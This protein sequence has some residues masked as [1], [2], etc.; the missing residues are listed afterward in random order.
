MSENY[1][2][3]N[4]NL[5]RLHTI[6]V[7]VQ[8]QP[9]VLSRIV[10]IFSRRG[11][12]IESLVVSA[13][14]DPRFSTMTITVEGEEKEIIQ[15]I[16]QLAKLVNVLSVKE[17]Q[18]S[19]QVIER[20]LALVKIKIEKSERSN[21]LQIVDHFK[22]HTIDLTGDSVIVQIT[23]T[24]EKVDACIS[25]LKSYEIIELIRSGKII[26]KRGKEKT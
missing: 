12:N 3:L 8:N 23:G 2:H 13:T 24:T 26:M 5:E 21:L 19:Y 11:F 9:S 17:Y 4:K 25:L 20:E 1:T 16:K 6:A 18:R 7:F 14:T 15:V 10:L 22:S